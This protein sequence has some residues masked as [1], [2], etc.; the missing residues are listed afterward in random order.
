MAE[1]E[2][3]TYQDMVEHVLDLYDLDRT[4]RNLRAARR[5]VMTAY[6]DLPSL[7][8]WSYLTRRVQVQTEASESHTVVYDHTG[9]AYE[10]QLTTTGTW[11][12][13]AAL[14]RVL[15][16]NVVYDIESRK[17]STVLTLTSSSNPGSDVAS[18][19]ATWFRAVYPM[20]VRFTRG[21]RL[22]DPSTGWALMPVTPQQVSVELASL[23]TPG[24]PDRY[25]F[26]NAS[27]YYGSMDVE[28]LPP[29]ST[30]K[31]YELMAELAPRPLVTEVYSTGTVSV[32]AG[33][34]SLTSS[35]A[36]FSS[37]YAGAIIRFSSDSVNLPTGPWGSIEPDQD[38]NSNPY[39]AQRVITSVDSATT[40]TLDAAVSSTTSLSGV[41]YTISDPIDI[42]PYAMMTLFHRMCEREFARQVRSE[43]LP[44]REQAFQMALVTAAGADHRNIDLGGVTD[45]RW[46]RPMKLS[47]IAIIQ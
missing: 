25:C 24:T 33:S 4:A 32:T 9:G 46:S 36:T 31:T 37:L 5:A 8:R 12:T 28:F 41:K 7:H 3:Q 15:I 19:S 22:M 20:P 45:W 14:G 13:N 39:F 38:G 16:S 42:E 44:M 10:R 30:A 18:T 17:S 34:S 43:E 11:P 23:Y 6:R 26:H 35:G 1:T 27:E 40:L 2:I 47:D 21:H 29:P